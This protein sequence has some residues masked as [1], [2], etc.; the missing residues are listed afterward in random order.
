MT[1]NENE[2][3]HPSAC[4]NQLK[5]FVGV[6][7]DWVNMAGLGLFGQKSTIAVTMPIFTAF[8]F[9]IGHT[10]NGLLNR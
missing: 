9:C 2:A 4:S 3:I 10:K 8:N 5:Y 7:I 1:K 6:S